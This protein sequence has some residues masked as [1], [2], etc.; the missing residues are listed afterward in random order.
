M[1]IN[2]KS[3]TTVK[4]IDDLAPSVEKIHQEMRTAKKQNGRRN[5]GEYQSKTGIIT[6][7]SVITIY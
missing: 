1:F 6:L 3:S 4:N 2:G 7:I 5:R